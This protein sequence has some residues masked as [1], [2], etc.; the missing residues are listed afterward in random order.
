MKKK[1]FLSNLGCSKN[2][3]DSESILG[4]LTGAGVDQSDSPDDADFIV[5]NTCGFIESA[6]EESIEEILSFTQHKQENQ[7]VIVAGCLSARYEEEL[8]K[9]IPEVDI[10]LGTYKEGELL[11]RIKPD[12]DLCND[13]GERKRLLTG[14]EAHHAYLKI[15]EG[16]NR[17]CSFCAIP[18]F[19]GKQISRTME[20]IVK[21]AQLLEN[22]GVKELTLIAQD[23]TFYGR[24]RGAE[25]NLESLLELL[26]KETGIPW[27]R[28]TYAY[29]AFITD[30]LLD[31]IANQK[32]ICNYLDMP[33]QH[34]SDRML[35]LMRR[36]H[37]R[38]SLTKILQK[39][40][41]I[42]DMALRTTVLLGF[43]GE[44]EQDFEELLDL[45]QEIK[46]D[47]L[48]GFTY[49][50]EEG[51]YAYD[52]DEPKVPLEVAEERLD[53]LMT[54]QQQ[55][56]LDRNLNLIGRELD[57]ILDYVPEGSPYHFQGR[58]QWDALEVDNFVNIVDG[59]GDLGTF[60]KVQILD[61]SE[62]DLEAKFID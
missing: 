48:G 60:R 7:K 34:A 59:S 10:F 13:D 62:Y 11:E 38:A 22:Q 47:R 6:K 45:A 55:I 44:T 32:R 36:G 29:P 33:I 53:I 12:L 14:E 61:A 56:S 43:P 41:Q 49:S 28:L 15:A 8:K 5:V 31:L 17:T 39:L 27:F 25:G 37:T 16:C 4:E 42:P 54:Q 57:V 26:L 30:K 9:E 51:T 2:L 19:R 23:L 52:L 1:V 21:E 40:R 58:T 50:D 3:V 46:F 24:E 35:K 20:D 18:S